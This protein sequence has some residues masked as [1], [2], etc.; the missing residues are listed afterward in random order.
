MK[1][2]KPSLLSLQLFFFIYLLLFDGFSDVLEFVMLCG[3]SVIF[4]ILN[5]SFRHSKLLST[6]RFNVMLVIFCDFGDL[7]IQYAIAEV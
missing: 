4:E 1:E 5:I 6:E 3:Y 7:S 2:L